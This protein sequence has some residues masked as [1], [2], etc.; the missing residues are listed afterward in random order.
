IIKLRAHSES[1][2]GTIL[3][4][5][6]LLNILASALATSLFLHIFGETGILYATVL[7]TTL[8]FIFGEV[9]PKTYAINNADR[10]ALFVARP[11]YLLVRVLEP[12]NWVVRRI[13]RGCLSLFGVSITAGLGAHLGDEELRGAIDL[14]AKGGS[15]ERDRSMMLRSILDMAEVEVSEIMTHRKNVVTIDI[16]QK[17][18]MVV[19]Q[20]LASPFTRIPLWKDQQDNIVG[21]LHA[22]QL[23]RALRANGGNADEIDMGAIITPPWFVPESTLLLDQLQAFRERREHFAIVVDEYG[24]LQGIVTLED[25]LEEIVGDIIDEY[26]VSVPGVRPQADGSYILNGTVTIRDLN[27]EFDWHLPDETAVTIAGL[28]LNEARQIPEVGQVFEFYNLRFEILRRQ[29][30]QVT[31]LRVLPPLPAKPSALPA[32]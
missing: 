14:H 26:D 7:M 24:T 5:N 6:T 15:E 2:I 19:D 11:V 20:A 27:R 30:N 28:I 4:F 3:L 29:R 22:K 18:S 31:S 9:L 21:V 13:V 1:L 25:I 17:S 16:N 32:A 12:L 8:I 23:L 10:G